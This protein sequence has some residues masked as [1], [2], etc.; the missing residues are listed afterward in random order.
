MTIAGVT[1]W[2]NAS[3]VPSGV[4][5]LVNLLDRS[6]C[7]FNVKAYTVTTCIAS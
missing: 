3:K 2:S 6:G 4:C 5:D 1:L 7:D